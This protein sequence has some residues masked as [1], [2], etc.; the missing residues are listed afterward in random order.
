MSSSWDENSPFGDGSRRLGESDTPWTMETGKPWWAAEVEK[1]N[2]PERP[3]Y[4]DHRHGEEKWELPQCSPY[5]KYGGE[6]Y[7]PCPTGVARNINETAP[8]G[9]RR[10]TRGQLAGTKV[11]T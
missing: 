5:P 11:I 2:G 1:H 4:G 8:Y 3:A 9:R 6:C 10:R 7:K